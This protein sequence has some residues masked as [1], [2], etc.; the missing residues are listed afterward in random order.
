MNNLSIDELLNKAFSL[1]C[2]ILGDREHALRAVEE[3]MARLDVTTAAQGKRLYYKPSASSWLRPEKA[4]RYRNKVLFSELHLLQRLVYIAS[5]PY[6]ERR[7]QSVVANKGGEEEML[8][9]FI[10]HLAR[11]TTRRN[12]FY[13]TLGISRLLYNYTT[14]ETMEVY[15]AVIQDPERVKDDYYYRS[16]KGVLMQEIKKRFGGLLEIA[17][18]PR[19]E[20]RFHAA[21][22]QTGFIELVKESLTFFTPWYTPCL[23]PAGVNPI[24]DGITGLE[25]HGKDEEDRIE[26]DRIHAVLHPDCHGRLIKSLG[27]DEPERRLEVPHF[28]LSQDKGNGDGSRGGRG[29][30]RRHARGLSHNELDEIKGH[31]DGQ[32]SRRKRAF[33]GLLR[34]VVDGSERARLDLSHTSSARFA[35]DGDAELMEVRAMVNGDDLLLASH[36]FKHREPSDPAENASIV[37][38]GGQKVAITVSPATDETEA[39]VDVAYRETNPFRA[40]SLYLKQLTRTEKSGRRAW[41]TGRVPA[42]ALAFALVALCAFG[43]VQFLRHRSRAS[44]SIASQ[45]KISQ[46][47]EENAAPVKNND[48]TSP[49]AVVASPLATAAPVEKDK[50]EPRKVSPRKNASAS[51]PEVARANEQAQPKLEQPGRRETLASRAPEDGGTRDATPRRNAPETGATRDTSNAVVA[52]P[53]SEV[54][55]IYVEING[56]AASDMR[57]KLIE[58]LRASNRFVSVESKDEADALMRVTV[59]SA[60]GAQ[61]SASVLVINARGETIWRGAGAR[62][63]FTG[64]NESVA[65]GIV[66]ELLDVAGKNGRH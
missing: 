27:F 60:G 28:F 4:D 15:N 53:L 39:I 65:G 54:K 46:P 56:D 49:G 44:E 29:D 16:R 25:S 35:L 17:R 11:I 2:F 6:E 42:L 9:H 7:E 52:V 12:S 50:S 51:T 30:D 3:A 20:E 43:V 45:P 23:V 10:K 63:V 1:A 24:M 57:E 37:L 59:K 47:G 66:K 34:V 31:L 18:G 62:G 5:E 48:V 19:G 58:S 41:S 26:V 55:K 61:V 36:L 8:I 64:S 21:P 33:A 38:E 22:E 14:A 40:F 32:S 13:V